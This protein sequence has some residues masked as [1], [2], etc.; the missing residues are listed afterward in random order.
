MTQSRDLSAIAVQIEQ[1]NRAALGR[2]LSWAESHSNEHRDRVYTLLELIER[3]AGTRIGISGLPGAGKSTLLEML[4]LALVEQGHRLGILAIDPS[5]NKTGGSILGDKTRMARLSSREE[6]FIRPSPSGGVLGGIT[7]G[8]N[9]QVQ[10]LEAAGHD[11]IFVE[12]V[13]IGQSESDVSNLVDYSVLV[14]VPNTGDELQ[15]IKRGVL[16]TVDYVLINKVDGERSTAGINACNQYRAALGV[17]RAQENPGP[18]VIAI[19]A[20]ENHGL[21]QFWTSLW[22]RQ[23]LESNNGRLALKRQASAARRERQLA[24]S[25]LLRQFRHFWDHNPNITP[26]QSVRDF[27]ENRHKK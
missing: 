15:G 13:G 11:I 6:V 25:L 9:L 4:G 27:L 22:S 21:Q 8:S 1:G 5:S 7:P 19:S 14:L 12:T 24:E 2:A 3:K 17:L 20:L 10:L 26:E 16:E 23:K 18:E